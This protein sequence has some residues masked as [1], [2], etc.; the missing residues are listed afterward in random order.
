MTLTRYYKR[1]L[2]NAVKIAYQNNDTLQE[3][4]LLKII[5]SLEVQK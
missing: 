1:L 2:K 5:D 3:L 4:K